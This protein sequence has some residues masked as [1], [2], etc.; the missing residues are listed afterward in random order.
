MNG[1]IAIS[2]TRTAKAIEVRL[3]V[4]VGKVDLGGG[5]DGHVQFALPN[6]PDGRTRRT[7]A[8]MTKTTVFEASG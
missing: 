7:I 1:A 5:F 2:A 4:A 3:A 8:M 6:R